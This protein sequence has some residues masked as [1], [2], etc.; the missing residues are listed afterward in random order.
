M[1]GS[2]SDAED[3]LQTVFLRLARREEFSIFAQ[4]GELL[5]PRAINAALDLVRAG[6]NKI[7]PA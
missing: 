4:P 6:S 3:V 5:N 7:S 1:T 2:V